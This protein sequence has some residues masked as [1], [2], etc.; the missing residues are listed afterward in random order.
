MPIFLVFSKRKVTICIVTIAVNNAI[1][2]VMIIPIRIQSLHDNKGN[3]KTNFPPGISMHGA[4]TWDQVGL[5]VDSL[6]RN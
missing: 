4:S 5:E 3:I 1:T 6:I 2:M